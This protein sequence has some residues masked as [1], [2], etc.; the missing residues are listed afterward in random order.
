MNSIERLERY[1]LTHLQITLTLASAVLAAVGY[2][3]VQPAVDFGLISKLLFYAALICFALSGLCGGNFAAK[4]VRLSEQA[5][6]YEELMPLLHV[7][8]K[9][10]VNLK[11]GDWRTG[12]HRFLWC[13]ILAAAFAGLTIQEAG[14]TIDASETPHLTTTDEPA[15]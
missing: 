3:A 10:I 8:G 6:W 13:G 5:P 1:T 12:Q 2:D 7:R 15:P 9:P 4:I 14:P 11:G